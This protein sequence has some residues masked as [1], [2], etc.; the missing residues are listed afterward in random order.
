M[1]KR[2]Y[3]LITATAIII[4]AFCFAL[5][6][7]SQ[8]VFAGNIPLLIKAPNDNAIYFVSE[9]LN[10]KK[11]INSETVFL[12]Y[13]DK[14]EWVKIVSQSTIDSYRDVRLVK[15]AES[16]NVYYILNG[17]KRL[18]PSPEVFKS[19]GFNWNEILTINQ[20][21]LDS[22]RTEA[23]LGAGMSFSG[24]DQIEAGQLTVSLV[25][26]QLSTIVVPDNVWFN[27][28]K[29]KF[30][31]SSNQPVFI[32]GLTITLYGLN[33]GDQ[34]IGEIYLTDI[35]DRPIGQPQT[36][37]GRRATF[38]LASEPLVIP[39]GQSQIVK[40]WTSAKLPNI[41]VGFG[42]E[43]ADFIYTTAQV[44]GQF[45]IKG[46]QYRIVDRTG[47]AGKANIEAMEISS[48]MREVVIGAD[49]QIITKFKISETSQQ[50]N[51]LLKK[52]ILSA[53]GNFDD[54]NLA[55]I[56]L[57]DERNRVLATAPQMIDDQ[58]IFDLNAKPLK[59]EAG[60]SAIVSVRGDFK[61]GKYQS[62]QLIIDSQADLWLE[63]EQYGWRLMAQNDFP[64][65][66]GDSSTFNKVKPISQPIS[67]Y[68]DYSGR[69]GDL[70][71]G[72]RDAKLGQ[73]SI[74]AKGDELEFEGLELKI[75]RGGQYNLTGDIT[76][77]LNG[78]TIARYHAHDFANT[79]SYISFEKDVRLTENRAYQF[80]IFGSIDDR[81]T[82]L[83]YYQ[84]T[85]ANFNLHN[86][87]YDYFG[88]NLQINSPIIRVKTLEAKVDI[89]SKYENFAVIAGRDKQ[90][91]GSFNLTI[92]AAEDVD[93]T[94]ASIANLSG[95]YFYD[96]LY[97]KIGNRLVATLDNPLSSP[98]I[99]TLTKPYKLS[100]GK[101][102]QINVYADIA[103]D[104]HGDQTALSVVDLTLIGKNSQVAANL[105]NLPINGQPV[106][107]LVSSISLNQ[108]PTNT[109]I[110]A[111][112]KK[113]SIARLTITNNS[114]EKVRIKELYVYQTP[115]SDEF[116]YVS[117]FSN[118]QLVISDN[119][120]KRMGKR[121]SKPIFGG[122]NLGS[123]NLDPFQSLTLD[124]M[125][126]T[127][128][129]AGNKSI[130][131][132]IQDIIASGLTSKQNLP[133]NICGD[134]GL[135]NINHLD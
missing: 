114:A 100:R 121:I 92:G 110:I 6:L 115:D 103:P 86:D 93:I 41:Y 128:L 135:I 11:L 14:W 88:D 9:K 95:N 66:L 58:I 25:D 105:D 19:L 84:L 32:N 2:N 37:R 4:M 36:F 18:I 129:E 112:E 5:F 27:F 61:G 97:L 119:Q 55:N 57:V 62:L 28:S 111:G 39:A 29:I 94:S 132:T 38:N 12:S 24:D 124:L 74:R 31:A 1:N 108:E 16:N 13:G 65:G 59:I 89:N 101:I 78:E 79:F 10:A 72:S 15:T 7:P 122:N 125:V 123:F 53:K 43:S 102:Y 98:H 21:D 71:A 23:P 104:A 33:N 127:S 134:S 81:A 83:D 131:L 3:K 126:D 130:E 118:L 40:V 82:N 96:K 76:I 80:E 42:L 35:N 68:A 52:I 120:R 63:G 99:F 60:R 51:I 56:D 30:T 48:Q 77:K 17:A 87:N 106:L 34:Q 44:S 50:Q 113:Q 90:L 45:P 117:G 49:N 47:L 54:S 73:F 20:T 75:S 26:E 109:A 8:E 69:A 22:Y 67:L 64:V 46:Y 116:S 107:S 91:I 70:V 133:I 85:F